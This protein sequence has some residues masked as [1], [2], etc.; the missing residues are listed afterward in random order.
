M[1]ATEVQ[2][3]QCFYNGESIEFRQFVLFDLTHKTMRFHD[4]DHG[5]AVE[6]LPVNIG[7]DIVFT[8]QFTDQRNH[9][10]RQRLA[11]LPI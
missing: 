1:R 5:A 2:R 8:V 11:L 7:V 4:V 3:R 10:F 6:L 9:V